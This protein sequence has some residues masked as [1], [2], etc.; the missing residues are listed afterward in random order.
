MHNAD[1]LEEISFDDL[2]QL[3]TKLKE[4]TQKPKYEVGQEVWF[5]D[6]D[7]NISSLEITHI[8]NHENR[9]GYQNCYKGWYVPEEKCYPSRESLIKA[10]I[11]YWESLKFEDA[12]EYV[13]KNHDGTIKNLASKECDHESY[14]K[15]YRTM[16]WGDTGQYKCTK[17]GEF[18]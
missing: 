12:I 17:C 4:L 6:V 2:D 14:G 16:E 11:D 8:N 15:L 18:Y 3:I 1:T 5:I 10:Q 13:Q 9:T 7:N